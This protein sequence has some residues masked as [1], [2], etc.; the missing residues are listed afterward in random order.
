[1]TQASLKPSRHHELGARQKLMSRIS[2]CS[3]ASVAWLFAGAAPACAAWSSPQT[4][5]SSRVWQYASAPGSYGLLGGEHP[6]VVTNA[7]GNAVVAWLRSETLEG[8][9]RAIEASTRAPGQAWSKPGVLSRPEAAGHFGQVALDAS[10]NAL[11]LWDAGKTIVAAEHRPGKS[12]SRPVGV[13]RPGQ[14]AEEPDLA[15]APNGAATAVFDGELAHGYGVLLSHRPPRGS[16]RRPRTLASSARGTLH[17]PQVAVDARGETI[18]AW[19]REEHFGFR[20][21]QALILDRHGRPR[22]RVQA[23]SPTGGHSAELRLALNDKGDAVLTW[24]QEERTRRPIEASARTRGGRF[25][26]AV[27]VSR[28]TDVEPTV[29]IDPQGDACL[30]FTRII[31]AQPTPE[32]QGPETRSVTT[33][34]AATRPARG[35]WTAP[36]Q[37]ASIG[38]ESTSE[39][40][41]ALSPASD[42]VIA[43]WIKGRARFDGGRVEASVGDMSGH[44]QA[45]LTISAYGFGPSVAVGR[46]DTAIAAWVGT[47]PEFQEVQT[48]DYSP[49]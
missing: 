26:A 44:W 46:D 8:N 29:T 7:S 4:I 45:P 34:E 42:R 49:G 9:L 23:L 48:S 25:T 21:V 30:L 43:I 19:V 12:W 47:S 1:M 24:S 35:R 20:W 13:S 28:A 18:V 2:L 38:S 27:V 5:A 14:Y 32:E 10:G 15:L 3:F 41:I 22:G 40:Q 37:L 11:A 36:R 6:Q 16:W 39:Q 17:E 33:V 31:R